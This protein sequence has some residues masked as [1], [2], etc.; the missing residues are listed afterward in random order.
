MSMSNLEAVS[1]AGLDPRKRVDFWNTAVSTAVVEA[2]ADPLDPS[3]FCGLLRHCDV[4]TIRL[5]EISAGSSVVNCPRTHNGHLL[6]QLMLSGEIVCRAD[7]G[8]RRARQGDFWLHDVSHPCKLLLGAPASMLVLRIPRVRILQ[9]IACPEALAQV[10]VTAGSTSGAL[11]S[12]FLREVWSSCQDVEFAAVAPRFIDIALQMIAS[13]YAAL[14]DADVNPSCL[15]TRH[16]VRIRSYIEDHLRDPDLTP[17]AI[18]HSLGCTP[19]YLHR[20]FS[21]QGESVG[22]YILRRR[23]E[24]CHRALSDRMQAHRNITTIAFSYGFNSLP[25]FCRKFREVYGLTP[26][27]LQ[28]ASLTAVVCR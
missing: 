22:Q 4:D 3:G 14:P 28:Q 11:V 10:V 26:R 7:G 27:G 17:T 9:H 6:L 23:L 24:E 18:A 5:A 13:S 21:P 25:H 2:V 16:R 19:G 15:Q 20:L 1:T 8:E 12:R